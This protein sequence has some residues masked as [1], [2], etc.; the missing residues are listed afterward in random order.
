MRGTTHAAIAVLSALALAVHPYG[1][2]GPEGPLRVFISVDMEGL[3]GVGTSEMVGSGGNDYA[4]GRQLATDEVNAVVE[5][6]FEHDGSAEILVNDSHGDMQNVHHT[7]LDPRVEYI[8]G[9]IKPLGMV[10]GLDDTFDAAIF[11]GYHSRAGTERGFLAHTGS[12]SVKGLWIDDLEVGEGGL[13]A[14][15][16]GAHGVPVIL[17]SGD[18]AFVGI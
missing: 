14:P 15:F 8:Q 16:A 4:L 1:L 5:A 7:Q 12:G 13:N 10:E 18:L 9:S 6:V 3:G 2:S 17:A 11:L